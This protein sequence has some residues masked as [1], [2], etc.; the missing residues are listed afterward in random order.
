MYVSRIRGAAQSPI[1]KRPPLGVL[2]AVV[3][4]T[5]L[6]KSGNAPAKVSDLLPPCPRRESG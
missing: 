6:S 1:L 3:K 4:S 5:L 2:A